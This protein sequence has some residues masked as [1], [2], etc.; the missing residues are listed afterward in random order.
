MLQVGFKVLIKQV[1]F[2]FSASQ[3]CGLWEL[4]H[5][6]ELKPLQ[7]ALGSVCPVFG[8]VPHEV[9]GFFVQSTAVSAQ[10]PPAR[11]HLNHFVFLGDTT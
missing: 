10:P 9:F 4:G 2:A 5:R 6:A 11:H 8:E 3:A 1:S 7:A